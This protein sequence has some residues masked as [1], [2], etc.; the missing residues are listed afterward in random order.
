[1]V[2][3]GSPAVTQKYANLI[4]GSSLNI[5]LGRQF[6]TDCRKWRLFGRMEGKKKACKAVNFAFRSGVPTQLVKYFY[7]TLKSHKQ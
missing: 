1:M 7:V 2:V 4:N 6:G 5:S 3:F